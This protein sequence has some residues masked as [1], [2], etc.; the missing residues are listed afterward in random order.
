MAITDSI[1]DTYAVDIDGDGDT[2]IYYLNPNTGGLNLFWLNDGNGNFTS[3]NVPGDEQAN[4]AAFGDFN[5]DGYL[6]YITN[7]NNTISQPIY[8]GSATNTFTIHDDGITHSI[9]GFE[10]ADFNGDNHLDI[11]SQGIIPTINRLALGDGGGNFVAQNI[12]NDLGFTY[13]ATVEDFDRD[14]DLDIFASNDQTADNMWI[15]DGSANFTNDTDYRVRKYTRDMIGGDFNNDGIFDLFLGAHLGT[16]TAEFTSSYKS[17]SLDIDENTTSVGTVSVNSV[18]ANHE[19]FISGGEDAA[20]FS[21]DSS[22]G[23]LNFIG[24]PDY[25]NPGDNNADN[26]YVVNVGYG[27]T[28][29]PYYTSQRTLAISVQDVEPELSGVTVEFGNENYSVNESDSAVNVELEVIGDDLSGQASQSIEVYIDSGTTTIVDDF[30]FTDPLTVTIP[31]ANYSSKTTI[32]VPI[33]IVDDQL[34]EDTEG[35]NFALQNPSTL[36]AEGAINTTTLVY[37]MMIL[38]GYR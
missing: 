24:N 1:F 37:K 26:V 11:Y 17:T 38:L 28:S 30:S 23:E 5:E 35:I 15:N 14:G 31:A 12:T 32:N 7:G 6:D 33:S 25:E 18:A 21:I 27:T 22:T 4:E 34:Q 3:L 36:A 2:D 13:N 20:G 9:H 29:A 8:F 16:N 10:V 19:F